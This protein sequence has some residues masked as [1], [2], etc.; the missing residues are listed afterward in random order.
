MAAPP[1][2]PNEAR[3][4]AGSRPA[5]PAVRTKYA[6]R[7]A[8]ANSPQPTPTASMLIPP[9][10]SS[11]RTRPPRASAMPRSVGRPGPAAAA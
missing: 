4:T 8:A 6:A 11:T 7:P 2:M 5:E 9:A 10:T 1:I 3:A